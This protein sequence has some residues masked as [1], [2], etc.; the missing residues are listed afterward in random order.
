M[1]FLI[2]LGAVVL[3]IIE[4]IIAAEA[5][6]AAELKGYS[7]K[8]YFWYTF[9]FGVIGILLVIALPDRA[10]PTVVAAPEKAPS[11]TVEDLPEL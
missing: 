8:K 7:E 11:A 10:T 3:L 9:I 1:G 4:Y 6:Y 5:M 2:F